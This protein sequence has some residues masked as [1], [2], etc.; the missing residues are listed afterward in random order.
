MSQIINFKITKIIITLRRAIFV[1]GYQC[2]KTFQHWRM[3]ANVMRMHLH[4]SIRQ[5]NASSYLI[6]PETL[7]CNCN[8]RGRVRQTSFP[9]KYS[10]KYPIIFCSLLSQISERNL[11]VGV[12]T[13]SDSHE[14]SCVQMVQRI[15]MAALTAAGRRRGGGTQ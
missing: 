15:P 10:S 7:H 13:E 4:I 5:R 3:T 8:R 11:I 12:R 9:N 2:N 14:I 1:I 6:F